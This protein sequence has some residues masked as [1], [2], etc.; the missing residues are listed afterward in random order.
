MRTV[1]LFLVCYGLCSLGCFPAGAKEIPRTEYIAYVPL[2]YPRLVRQTRASDALH[3]YGNRTDPGYRDIDP[4]DG[5][6]DRR[7]NVLLTLAVRFAPY[8]VQNSGN[9]PVNFDSYAEAGD[10]FPLYADTWD[11]T[12]EKSRLINS[13]RIDFNALRGSGSAEGT[14][15]GRAD[16]AAADQKLLTL[17]DRFTPG[18]QPRSLVPDPFVKQRPELFTVLFFDL[19]GEG[20]DSWR[21]AYRPVYEHLPEAKRSRFPHTYVHPFLLEVTGE[22]REDPHYELIM[23]YWFYYPSNDGGNNH[24]GDWEHMNV[25]IAPRSMVTQPLPGETVTRILTGDL[26]A[27]DDARDPLVIRRVEYYFHHLVMVLD[28]TRPNVYQP[29]N[30]W[31]AEVR[32]MPKKRFQESDIWEAIRYMAYVDG[33]ETIV[34]T[35]PLGYIGADN[36]GLDQALSAPGGKNRNSH[37]TFPFPGRYRNIGP[38][39]ATEQISVSAD[40]RRYWKR[41]RGGRES[42]GPEFKRGSIIGLADPERIRIVPDWERV[43]DLVRKDATARRAWSWLVLPIRW[44][45]PATES[46][47]SGIIS[48]T[49]TG[50]L[51]PV[52]PAFSSGWNVSGPAQEF[53]SYEPHTLPSVFPLGLQDS[54]R[55]DF[56]F[57]NFTLPVLFNAPPLDFMTRIGTYPFKL[58]FSRRDPVYYPEE[59]I[60]YRFFGVSS[61][62]SVQ[63]VDD[64]FNALA[65]NSAQYNEFVGRFLVHFLAYGGDSTTTVRGGAD[66]M[67]NAVGPFIQIPFYIGEHFASENTIRNVRTTF[68]VDV[69]FNNI[70]AYR[71]RAELN[72][73]EYAGSLR[74]NLFTSR[75]QPFVKGGY[76]WSW[77]RIENVRANGIPFDP[78]QSKWITPQHVWPNVWHFGAG[79]EFVPWRRT[80]PFPRGVEIAF[81]AEYAR[82]ME[83]LGLDL[84]GVSLDR[85]GLLFPTLG[86]VPIG[87]RVVRN[88]FLFG[89]CVSF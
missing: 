84:S 26:S 73:W 89:L 66:I 77:Y 34:N 86:E 14:G 32:R 13:E 18:E 27:S 51:A 88:D 54:F 75:F 56:G 83:S 55:N 36:K 85:L 31:K 37:G 71:Y 9:F 30:A 43:I 24:E 60:P 46:P 22:A 70:P 48:H 15:V 20:P 81:R 47:F 21:G 76:G 45:Y 11:V 62:V 61:G 49:D 78:A 23:Q 58:A 25:V 12:G 39:G 40:I 28:F 53:S 38:A 6:D 35:H 79:I 33:E 4:V 74:Y 87:N 17:L 42:A 50:N 68:G 1:H 16:A 63:I 64:D 41:L 3:L 80:G 2:T 5:I 57:F 67:E 19:P 7:H 69:E 44:G 29:R 8:L 10:T 72:Y 82:Y 52:G 59:G 65:F